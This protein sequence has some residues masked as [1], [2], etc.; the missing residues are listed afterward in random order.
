MSLYGIKM[1]KKYFTPTETKNL[2]TAIFFSKL[3][4]GAEVWHFK[5]LAR[6]LHKKLKYASA[7]ALKIC[8]PGVTVFS[9]HSEIHTMADRATPD[10]ICQY[11]HAITL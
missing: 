6:S 4:Y 7:N 11:R 9:A 2:I 10:Q 3:Y 1:T 5:G 8:T